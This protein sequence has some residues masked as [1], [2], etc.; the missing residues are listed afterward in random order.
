MIATTNEA[1]A[2]SDNLGTAGGA[3]RLAGT[4]YHF[5][6]AYSDIMQ[7]KIAVPRIYPCTKDGTDNFAPDNC[8]LMSPDVL[9]QKRRSQGLY[10]F[11][12]QMLLSPKGDDAQ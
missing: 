3:S 11:S 6:D 4:R 8:V 12:T 7:R 2:P 9:A 10:V 5:Q 1:L